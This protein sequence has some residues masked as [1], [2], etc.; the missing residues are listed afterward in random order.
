MPVLP[1]GYLH[2]LAWRILHGAGA[3]EEEARIVA[4]HL[5][6]ANLA[7][8][9]SHGIIQVPGY[10]QRIKKGHIRPGAPVQVVA[11]TAT[12]A[13]INGN[14]GFG[15]V[16]STRA[17]E[18]AIQKAQKS[19]VAAVTVFQQ[20]HVGRLTDYPLM[21]AREGMIAMMTAD[22]GRTAKQV[23]PFGGREPRLGTNPICLALPSDLEGPVFMDF[24]TSAVAGGKLIVARSRGEQV[25][26]G[27]IIDKDGNP[28]TDPANYAAILPVGGNQGHKG[29][30]LSF[31]VEVMSG[32]LTGLGF[33]HDPSGPHNDGCFMAVF[34]VD[35]FV[36]LSQFKWEL[37]E[38]V[39]YIKA[40]PPA[41]GFQEVYYP[42][43]LEW[44]TT[45]RRTREGIY[46]EEATWRELQALV[47]EYGLE[48]VVGQP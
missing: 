15:Y 31:M 14:W 3:P 4:D 35:A 36:P 46:V 42:G 21:A 8:H 40:C 13:R 10:V 28:T 32:I 33:G 11:E 29:Y 24:A 25:P 12:T 9:D 45:Q 30:G 18:L 39:K 37:G 5:I 1:H 48:S 27:W 17:M 19:N 23:A 47:K 43:E 7:G 41:Q 38:F 44:R 6:G 26:L 20:G 16:V 2:Q 22:S 34:K